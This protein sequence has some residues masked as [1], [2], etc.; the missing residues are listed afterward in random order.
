[1]K[2]VATLLDLVEFQR[3]DEVVIISD[4]HS[5]EGVPRLLFDEVLRRGGEVS[6]SR[7]RAR[8]R[9]GE[10]LP[11]AV[12]AA[13]LDCDLLMLLTS[14]SPTHSAGV[15]QAVN[16]GVRVISMP[17]LTLEL[18]ER[19]GTTADYGE[20]KR[21]TD[22]WGE[23]FASGETIR[24]TTAAGTDVEAQLGGPSR[25]PFLDAGPL[26]RGKGRLGNFP[27]GE[28]AICP[29]E[30]TVNG[31][32]VTDLTASTSPKPLASPIT[33]TIADGLVVDVEGG[34][35][36]EALSS[37]LDHTGPGSRIV[38]EIALG[39]NDRALHTGLILEDEKKLGSAHLGLGNSISFGGSNAI[40]AHI[41]VV[42]DAVTAIV[43]GMA[44]LVD[45]SPTRTP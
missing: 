40:D 1:V 9:N 15:M 32:V 43:D 42:F 34:E 26:P 13:I 8:D 38:G 18:M 36:A 3:D 44:L 5:N 17:G 30:G 12:R 23:V 21:L 45:G 25:L 29:V 27:A 41:D 35:E 2:S 22:R 16:A 37:F 6:W 10:E 39:T 20:V 28:V 24:L 4:P 14:W 33:L 19:G 31:R 7:V 11:R